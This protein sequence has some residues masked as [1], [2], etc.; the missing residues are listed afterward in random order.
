MTIKWG[1]L[2][3]ANIAEKTC[4]AIRDGGNEVVA[5][6][7][8]SREKAATWS[9]QHAPG[10]TPY[11]SYDEV[12]NDKS[13]QVVYIPLPTNMKVEWVKKAAKMGKHVLCEK[14]L[15]CDLES[16]TEMVQACEVAGVQF[17]DNTMFMHNE[18][19]E[20]T[21]VALDDP[22]FGRIKQV[23]SCFSIACANDPDWASS[24]IRMKKE[25]E[26]L[27]CLGDLGWY[28]VRASLW[29][30]EYEN[31]EAVRCDFLET[32]ADGVPITAQ[33]SMRFSGG[34]SASFDCSFKCGLRQWLEVVGERRT[35]TVTD[36][37][38]PKEKETVGFQVSE[39]TIGKGAE[40]FPETFL[41]Q[42]TLQSAVQHVKLTQ[43]LS[44]L[45]VSGKVVAEWPRIS[46]Q[47]HK[48]LLAMCESGEKNGVWVTDVGC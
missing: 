45:A 23:V 28:C 34:R 41:Q 16:A 8:R 31:P 18:R 47:T 1:V 48:I 12:L 19:L 13:V 15:S 37:V 26:P 27:G 25:T 32:T 4:R 39:R 17:M 10:A 44:E 42:A 14:P 22:N 33:A 9:S 36:F 46:L 24:N 11:G 6:G 5:V 38:I 29:A 7:S 20:K 43:R 3:C 30:F 40:T 2:G 21:K 35:L